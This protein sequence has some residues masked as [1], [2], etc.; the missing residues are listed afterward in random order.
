MPEVEVVVKQGL[1]K[2]AM[3]PDAMTQLHQEVNKKMKARQAQLCPCDGI[4]KNRPKSLKVSPVA[5]L[6]HKLGHFRAVFDLLFR[7]CLKSGAYVPSVTKEAKKTAPW[8]AIGQI[9]HALARIV[10]TIAECGPED[11][12]F[13]AKWGTKDGF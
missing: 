6:P 4:C 1:H 2:S 9:G 5:M 8:G 12:A 13:L 7:L 3:C 11:L 10:H